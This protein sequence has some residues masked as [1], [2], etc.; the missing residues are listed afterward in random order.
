MTNLKSPGGFSE[1]YILESP[2]FGFFQDYPNVVNFVCNFYHWQDA[3]WCIRYVTVF[4]E[5]LRNGENCAKKLI[6]WVILWVFLCT[7]S[8][9]LW[10][11]LQ[12]FAKWKTFLIYI[13]ICDKF[14]HYR[15]CGSEI[16][17]F[18]S[19][20]INSASMKWPL[21]GYFLAPISPNIVRSCWNFKQS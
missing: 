4:I 9:T 6:F 21:F 10:I 5:P 20:L 3:K 16:K 14:H 18:Q 8:S 19:F 2:L 1:K 13:Y 11:T 7:P 12:D 15:I 17:N